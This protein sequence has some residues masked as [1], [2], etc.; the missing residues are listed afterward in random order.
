LRGKIDGRQHFGL[1]C[2]ALSGI[3][4]GAVV[5]LDFAGVEDVSASWIAAALIPLL[6]WSATPDND[7]YPVLVG[8]LGGDKKWEDEF[9]LVAGRAG[10]VFLAAESGG[11]G[12]LMGSLDPILTDT[13]RAVQKYGGVT[14]AGLKRLMPDEKIGATAWS[15]RLK[16]LHAKRLVRRTTRGREQVYTNI[17]EVNF[18]GAASSGGAG[19]ELPSA[20]A[21]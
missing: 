7:L 10:A 5:S 17:L 12:R 13:L 1:L 8:V 2:A 15:N 3:R 11:R 16:D 9:E 21:T 20:D 6:A 18:R 14:G 19:R 4:P